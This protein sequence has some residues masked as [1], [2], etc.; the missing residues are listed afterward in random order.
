MKDI[1]EEFEEML[2]RASHEDL[3]EENQED[4]TTGISSLDNY[5]TDEMSSQDV[6]AL[7][8]NLEV[9]KSVN[10]FLKKLSSVVMHMKNEV[11]VE[12]ILE[13]LESL[14]DYTTQ[15][16]KSTIEFG[17][18]LYPPVDKQEA[19]LA[20]TEYSLSIQNMMECC[21]RFSQPD[22]D[23][24]FISKPPNIIDAE[25]LSQWVTSS[26]AMLNDQIQRTID[27]FNALEDLAIE[28]ED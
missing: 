27:V 7:S 28:T 20:L 17:F 6:R 15:L 19:L 11:I 1:T 22:M 5:T 23:N 10:E 2:N 8:T 14:V 4:W 24:C 9:F 3:K 18:C 16:S 12:H 26:K 13:F 25:K 21:D